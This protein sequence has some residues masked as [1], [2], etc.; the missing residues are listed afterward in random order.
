[1]APKETSSNEGL[2]TLK[3]HIKR[4]EFAPLYF[5]YGDERY[6]QEHY[7]SVLKKKL[8]SGPMEEFNYRHLT[9]ETFS[10]PALHDAVEALPMM[11]EYTLVQVDDVNPFTRDE[12]TRNDL[13]ELFSDLP[14]TC[15]LLFY[16]DTESY[17]PDGRYKN[18]T[19][20]VEKYATRVEFAKQSAH[21]LAEWISRH[22]RALEKT[23]SPDLCQHLIFLTGG[24]MT[25]LHS[26]IA[27]VA[28]YSRSPAITKV[29]IDTV[30]EPVLT[31]VMF[32]ITD[33]LAEG[34]YDKALGKLR[35]V[36]QTREDPIAILAT[37]GGHFRKLLTAKAN[38]AAGRGADGLKS[39]LG[40]N[41]DF[42][43]RKVAS[44]AAKVSEEFCMKAVEAC[45]DMD[46]KLKST[47][48]QAEGE[49]LL[50]HLLLTLAQEAAK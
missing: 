26:E 22:F 19:A 24:D 18:L 49:Q 1:M 10:L 25:T 35:E 12:S 36:L 47:V 27:K 39:L 32:D 37:V 31:A 45:Y 46:C 3:Q 21:E 29:D 20:A 42:Y 40:S 34:N 41:S 4:N 43:C 14:D 5:F 6:L 44:Q 28:A 30:V 2:Q 17:K 9:A 16:F 13:A 15:C 11:A 23:I 33:A 48:S 50:Y 8:V 38:A 7:L